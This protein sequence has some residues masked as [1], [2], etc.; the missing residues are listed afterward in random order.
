MHLLKGA[1]KTKSG[2]YNSLRGLESGGPPPGGL[3]PHADMN[4]PL[5]LQLRGPTDEHGDRK[6]LPESGFAY[7]ALLCFPSLPT[8]LP[9]PWGQDLSGFDQHHRT[10][11]SPRFASSCRPK[12]HHAQNNRN[13]NFLLTRIHLID[14]PCNIPSNSA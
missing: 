6:R 2:N 8:C 1:I 7:H 4:K 13:R 9:S 10:M 5:P 14:P 11:S 3:W 12:S